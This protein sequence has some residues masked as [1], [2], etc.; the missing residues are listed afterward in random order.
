[1]PTYEY[2]CRNCGHHLE[3]LQSFA[4]P[5]LLRC[6]ECGTNSL[7]RVMGTGALIFRGTGFYLTDYKKQ[8]PGVGP[9]KKTE[10]SEDKKPEEKK[11]DKGTPSTDTASTPK[12]E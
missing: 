3:E 2:Q 11:G 9:G 7:T 10:K 8:N 12:K 1:M 6:P 4:E 5:P